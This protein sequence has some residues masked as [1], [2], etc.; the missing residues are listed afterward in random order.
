MVFGILRSLAVVQLYLSY[1]DVADRASLFRLALS[2]TLRS[3]AAGMTL[4]YDTVISG[5]PS[6]L[7]SSLCKLVSH[8]YGS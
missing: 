3:S 7:D 6:R 1:L 5:H 2:S 8:S 4:L